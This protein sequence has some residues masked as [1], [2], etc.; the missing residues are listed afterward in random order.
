M[1][2]FNRFHFRRSPEFFSRKWTLRFCCSNWM[3]AEDLAGSPAAVCCQSQSSLESNAP[4]AHTVVTQWTWSNTVKPR[5]TG[6][7]TPQITD[8]SSNGYLCVFT[9]ISPMANREK[10]KKTLLELAKLPGNSCCAECGAAGKYCNSYWCQHRFKLT[11]SSSLYF[12]RDS[13]THSH[14][15]CHIVY[16]FCR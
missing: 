4:E 10:N 13:L 14:P 12:N 2:L 7:I 15:V 5:P 6:L 16:S 11:A 8:K 1:W 9:S 3:L